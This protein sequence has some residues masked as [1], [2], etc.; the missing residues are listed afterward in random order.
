M[1]CPGSATVK[2]PKRRV[3]P[4]EYL[5]NVIINSALSSSLRRLTVINYLSSPNVFEE[6]QV[7]LHHADYS[8]SLPPNI[9]IGP[10]H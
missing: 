4:K 2:T 7:L 5:E 10:L 6:H 1:T 8:I 9:W 3:I